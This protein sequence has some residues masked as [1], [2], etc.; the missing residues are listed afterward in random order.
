MLMFT[1]L[2]QQIKA[3]DQ[4]TELNTG[5]TIINIS[6]GP[7]LST[8]RNVSNNNRSKYV[9]SLGIRRSLSRNENFSVG[10]QGDYQSLGVDNTFW[11][12]RKENLAALALPIFYSVGEEQVRLHT[13]I[14]PAYL[15]PNYTYNRVGLTA[16]VGFDVLLGKQISLMTG[17]RGL[18]GFGHTSTIGNVALH[19][20][21]N[22]RFPDKRKDKSRT[23][24]PVKPIPS[25]LNRRRK[26]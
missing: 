6:G 18:A 21:L 4:S 3:Q 14:G 17:I 1:G 22:F 5:S 2:S 11:F 13:G 19:F 15:L 12:S 26:F 9:F 20:G 25:H 16:Q 10:L 23:N 7:I 24:R 8:D